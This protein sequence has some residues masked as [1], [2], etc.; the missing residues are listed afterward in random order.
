MIISTSHQFIFIHVPKTAGWSMMDT[1]QPYARTAKR[2]ILRSISRRLPFHESP[3]N[4]HF[5]VHE[6][7]SSMIAKLGRPVWD[8]FLTFA[9]VRDP[10]DHAVSHYE[11]LKQFRIPAIRHKF[12]KLSFSDY[13]D[14]RHRAVFWNHTLFV[15]MPDQAHFV[16]DGGG[17]IAVKRILR[18]ERLAEEWP[19]LVTELSIAG[20]ELLYVNKTRA[21]SDRR[22]YSSYY[23]DKTV[24][25]VRRL[26]ARDFDLF[27]YSRDLPAF[28]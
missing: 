28:G 7:A 26:Y 13:L 10:F 23:D 6:P 20:T 17:E 3:E 24:E 5:R 1:L 16:V 21:K 14:D 9:V 19:K 22:P 12:A 4:A 27:G 25:K 18:F 8:R 11:Y 2:T 15:R